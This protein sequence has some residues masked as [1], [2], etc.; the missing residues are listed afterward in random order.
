MLDCDDE[1]QY[2]NIDA[3]QALVAWKEPKFVDNANLPV[4][5][6]VNINNNVERQAQVY[7]VAYIARDSSGNRAVCKFFVH[8]NG[9]SSSNPL[10]DS[11]IAFYF[12]LKCKM[13]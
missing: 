1:N 4:T 11:C 7:Y 10:Y 2:I 3:K 12:Y 9:T 13:R 8:V 5:V 6:T